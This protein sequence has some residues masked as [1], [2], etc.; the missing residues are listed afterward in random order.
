MSLQP[1]AHLVGIYPHIHQPACQTFRI[2]L[3]EAVLDL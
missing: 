2:F 3:M 1:P